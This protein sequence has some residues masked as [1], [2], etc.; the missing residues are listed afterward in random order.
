MTST[1]TPMLAAGLLLAA[2][3]AIGQIETIPLSGTDH[4]GYLAFLNVKNW[5]TEA[6]LLAPTGL[7]NYPYWF[8]ADFAGGVFSS[9]IA[10]PLSAES[11]YPIEPAIAVFNKTITDPDFATRPAG[12]VSF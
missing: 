7:P 8:N 4:S 2:T 11:M 12:S 10:E 6:E 5:G 1:T 3:P 9:I